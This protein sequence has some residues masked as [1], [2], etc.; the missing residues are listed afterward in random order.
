MHRWTPIWCHR[1]GEQFSV[2]KDHTFGVR[3]KQYKKTQAKDKT[4]PTA[5]VSKIPVLSGQKETVFE[6]SFQLME[7]QTENL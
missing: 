2:W 7:M 3:K 5:D 6:D 4:P 1:T